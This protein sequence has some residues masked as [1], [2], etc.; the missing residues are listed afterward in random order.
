MLAG[1]LGT[2]RCADTRGRVFARGCSCAPAAVCLWSLLGCRQPSSPARPARC[3]SS[4]ELRPSTPS[5]TQSAFL[6]PATKGMARPSHGRHFCR[7]ARGTPVSAAPAGASN[8]CAPCL[9]LSSPTGA[10]GPHRASILANP[11]VRPVRLPVCGGTQWGLDIRP[12]CGS[13]GPSGGQP[14][15]ASPLWPPHRHTLWGVST[16]PEHRRPIPSLPKRARTA[17]FT[18]RS[19]RR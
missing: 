16:G 12:G 5:D 6:P 18:Q 10:G 17:G 19:W 7:D 14:P 3:L 4:D 2:V 8:S 11:P 15:P 9:S 13:A 1:L